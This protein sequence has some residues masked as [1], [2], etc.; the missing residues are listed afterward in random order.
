MSA[1]AQS[2]AWG[3][4]PTHLPS[5]RPATRWRTRIVPRRTWT[6]AR[7]PYGR[8]VGG[9]RQQLQPP[10]TCAEGCSGR[11]ARARPGHLQ[12]VRG[13]H[14]RV[15]FQHL[16]GRAGS[17]AGV[18]V[19]GEYIEAGAQCR[20]GRPHGNG[21]Q[22]ALLRSGDAGAAA[23][24]GARRRAGSSRPGTTFSEH[25]RLWWN[26]RPQWFPGHHAHYCPQIHWVA[27]EEA[28]PMLREVSMRLG[29]TSMRSI[30]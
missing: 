18:V 26:S 13:D 22:L 9:L 25:S 3:R 24:T 12:R 2:S 4:I 1:S 27:T 30:I 11:R 5:V 16:L 20:A 15:P 7:V 17:D 14:P 23:I 19:S 29:S 10:G 21:P 28:V 8:H 6:C